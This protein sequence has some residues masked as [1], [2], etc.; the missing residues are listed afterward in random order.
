MISNYMITHGTPCD[1]AFIESR[2]PKTGR[3]LCGTPSPTQYVLFTWK[4]TDAFTSSP[5]GAKVIECANETDMMIRWQRFIRLIDPD[6]ISGY[7]VVK[8]DNRYVIKRAI[9]LKLDDND[10]ILG[11]GS[12]APYIPKPWG[13][14]K[15]VEDIGKKG[16]VETANAE[17]DEDLVITITGRCILDVYTHVIRAFKLRSNTLDD[18]S[19]HFLNTTKIGVSHTQITPMWEATG[20]TRAELSRYCLRD[21]YLAAALMSKLL[22]DVNCVAVSFVVLFDR[23]ITD[24]NTP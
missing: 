20:A 19:K 11:R 8:F 12:N 3:V 7:N 9:A 22:I 23:Q 21:S 15:K 24:C 10:R 6:I 2:D 13:R 5:P 18:V 17:S 16:K 4:P 1:E 14:T